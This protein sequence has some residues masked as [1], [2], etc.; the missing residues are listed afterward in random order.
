MMVKGF[1]TFIVVVLTV[2]IV[3]VIV[4]LNVNILY[5]NSFQ[6]DSINYDTVKVNMNYTK[7]VTKIPANKA[8]LPESKCYAD[9]VADQYEAVKKS[10]NQT[11][12]EM[13][14]ECS[15]YTDKDFNS[16]S[17]PNVVHLIPGR[18]FKF[19]HYLNIRAIKKILKPERI[20]IHGEIFPFDSKFFMQAVAEFDLDLVSSRT[21][22]TIFNNLPV[23]NGEHKADL[24]RMEA[25]LK[26]GGIY[27]DMDAYPI[28]SFERFLKDE[29]SIGYQNQDQDYG[30]NNGIL[31]GKKCSRFLMHWYDQYSYFDS[32]RWDDHSV[33]LP[34]KLYEKY[35]NKSQVKAYR[36][37]LVSWW[38]WDWDADTLPMFKPYKDLEWKNVYA[39]HSFYRAF[40]KKIDFPINFETVKTLDNSFGR[41]ARYVLYDGP[42]M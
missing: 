41:F 2:L 31:I 25:I 29:F 15:T 7:A 38:A 24:L 6:G 32:E 18:G 30:L 17:V 37:E 1:K 21:V 16:C 39:V 34:L 40:A 22:S 42:Q 14:E 12:D 35:E 27:L 3:T 19:H 9:P 28:K 36:H 10:S 11:Y 8:K 4:E 13:K 26:Y 33:Q 23:K 20:Y 5:A